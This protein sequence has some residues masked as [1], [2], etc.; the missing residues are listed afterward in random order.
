MIE[1]NLNPDARVLRQFGVTA[2]IAFGLLGAAAHFQRFV[3]SGLGEAGAATAAGLWGVGAIS[4][5]LALVHP[6]A[7]RPLFVLL[8]VIT[9][10]LGLVVSYLALGFLFFFVF[11]PIGLFLRATGRDPMARGFNP[12]RTSY[13][14]DARRRRAKSSYFRQF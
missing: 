11:A 14:D 8:S 3:F 1:L 2:L 9:F 7:N 13:W 4:G 10:P 12:G 5:V 6:R